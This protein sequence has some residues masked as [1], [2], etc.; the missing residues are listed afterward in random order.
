[1]VVNNAD[2]VAQSSSSDPHFLSDNFSNFRGS[3]GYAEV[4]AIDKASVTPEEQ[5]TIIMNNGPGKLSES[6]AM[7]ARTDPTPPQ[8]SF[9]RWLNCIKGF[10]T[11][12]I[13]F[14]CF[15]RPPFVTAKIVRYMRS[16]LVKMMA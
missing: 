7:P 5:L 13:G 6:S 11:P 8:R 15:S 10:E 9:T 16:S 1:M 4:T 12:S 14:L 2:I 3:V